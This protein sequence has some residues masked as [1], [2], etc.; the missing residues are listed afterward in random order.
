MERL[1]NR[2]SYLRGLTDGLDISETSKEGQILTEVIALLDEMCQ[3]MKVL[4]T[5][6][7]ECEEYVEAVDED[8]SDMEYEFYGDDDELYELVHDCDEDR[9]V[10]TDENGRYYDLDDSEDA[11]VYESVNNDDNNYARSYEFEC[12]A[13]QETLFFRED[14]DEEG[15]QHYVIEP[16]SYE[17]A[18]I[19]PT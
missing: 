11:Y 15:F 14:Q 12:P 2:L 6:V 4:H 18:P 17:K 3:E 5:R 13:C 10:L 1:Q 7:E 8:L 19:N 16:S 9:Y